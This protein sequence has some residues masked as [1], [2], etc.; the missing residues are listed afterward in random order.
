MLE[1]PRT[2]SICVPSSQ[3]P[4]GIPTAAL[5][6]HPSCAILGPHRTFSSSLPFATYPQHRYHRCDQG[7]FAELQGSLVNWKLPELRE[8]AFESRSRLVSLVGVRAYGRYTHALARLAFPVR[9]PRDRLRGRRAHHLNILCADVPWD[10]STLSRAPGLLCCLI[11]GASADCV[12]LPIVTRFIRR[13]P[14]R[15]LT[16]ISTTPR[17]ILAQSLH[18][19]GPRC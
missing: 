9:P 18:R 13:Q 12:L 2:C 16:G 10:L 14:G 7:G 1:H 5:P 3:H 4:C 19:S 17:S 15:P 6:L 11:P 8:S